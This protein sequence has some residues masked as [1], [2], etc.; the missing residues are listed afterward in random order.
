MMMCLSSKE[1]CCDS[2]C[3]VNITCP[4]AKISW[5]LPGYYWSHETCAWDFNGIQFSI[6]AK[7]ISSD[8]I[9]FP[10]S[11]LKNKTFIVSFY[12]HFSQVM[13][14][15]GHTWSPPTPATEST[16]ADISSVSWPQTDS[17]QEETYMK[18][19]YIYL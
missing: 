10:C 1:W 17:P 15:N 12:H 14:L 5:F 4:I 19:I 13:I 3:Y 18:H 8:S 16:A 7:Q 11:L 2:W 9:R 6:D